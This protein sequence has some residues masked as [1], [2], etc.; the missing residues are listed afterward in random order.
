MKALIQIMVLGLFLAQGPIWA[1]QQVDE[2]RSANPDAQVEIDVISGSIQITGWDREEIAI[3]GTVGD[4][5]EALDISTSD[6][7][8]SIDLDIP[9]NWGNRHKNIDVDLEISV[10]KGIRLEVETISARID[11]TN[12][13]GTVDLASISGGIAVSGALERASVE[14]VSGGI[15]IHGE[16]TRFETE[17]VSGS[18]HLTGATERVEASTVSGQIKVSGESV[19]RAQ[20]ESVAGRIEFRGSLSTGARLD[21]DIHSGGVLLELPADTSARF[22]IETF[23]GSIE[24]E[25]GPAAERSD[26]YSPGKWLKFTTGDGDAE[27]NV[28][29]FSG[30]VRLKK[31]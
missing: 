14:T 15:E 12:L 26:R 7:R 29:S 8:I 2:T 1:A 18:I 28:E 5:V 27:I 11:A 4:D 9:D 31:L 6:G 10:P 16:Q 19:E 30:T 17:S 21:A 23:S 22:E 13:S 3:K 25:F 24:N 20:F